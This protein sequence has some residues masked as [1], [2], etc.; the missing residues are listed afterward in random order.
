VVLVLL[1]TFGGAWLY[2]D[3]YVAVWPT[4]PPQPVP[5]SSEEGPTVVDAPFEST[6]P[7]LPP[8]GDDGRRPD[9]GG[10]PP[11]TNPPRPETPTLPQLPPITIP[12]ELPALPPG[13]PTEFPRSLPTLLPIPG[14][15][16]PGLTGTGDETPP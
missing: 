16:A 15:P 9:R 5:R 14:L 2:Y 12:T 6:D 3:Q 8:I 11:R 1:V 13:I 10:T 4:P 7:E